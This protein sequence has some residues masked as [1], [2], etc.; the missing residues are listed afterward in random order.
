VPIGEAAQGVPAGGVLDGRDRQ[1]GAHYRV[2]ERTRE[3]AGAVQRRGLQFEAKPVEVAWSNDLEHQ[4]DGFRRQPAG[5]KSDH[6][7]DAG[8]PV[9]I[10]S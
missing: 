10:S 8:I 3:D 2:A 1:V 5:R 9:L 4:G 7:K 6:A